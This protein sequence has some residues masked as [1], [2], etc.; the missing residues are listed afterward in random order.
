MVM[1][2]W[3]GMKRMRMRFCKFLFSGLGSG[4]GDGNSDDGGMWFVRERW[5]D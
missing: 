5:A 3:K 2:R 1:I 4:A